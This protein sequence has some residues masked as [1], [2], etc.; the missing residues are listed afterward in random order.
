MG[1][2]SGSPIGTER[3]A[4]C[5]GSAGI[6]G[7]SG[8]GHGDVRARRALPTPAAPVDTHP[9]AAAARLPAATVLRKSRLL[10]MTCAIRLPFDEWPVEV[11]QARTVERPD[12]R[13]DLAKEGT[14]V[15]HQQ[16]GAVVLVQRVLEHLD[17]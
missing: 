3:S 7:S 9:V 8:N 17:V 16:H 4:R 2:A 10:G 14:V 12:A 5:A 13:R 1:N 11:D 15:A 6:G